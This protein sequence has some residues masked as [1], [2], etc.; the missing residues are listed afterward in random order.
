MYLAHGPISYIL[1]ETIQ[2]KEISKLTKQEQILVMIL[3][4]L[5]GILPDIDLAILSMTNIPPFQHHLIF[6]HSILFFIFLWVLLNIFFW[7][8]K[9]ILNKES[10]IVLK[11]SLLNV[12]QWSFLIGTLSHLFADLLFSYSVSLFPLQQQITILG[13]VFKTNYFANYIFTPSSATEILFISI[14]LM[15]IARRYFK[16]IKVVELISYS[17]IA[18]SSIYL[19][20]AVYMNLNTYNKAYQFE[21][22]IRI[23]DID[24][25]GIKDRIDS[26]TNSNRINNILEVNEEEMVSFVKSISTDRYFVTNSTDIVGKIKYGFGA[27]GSYRLISQAFFDQNLPIE[28]VLVEYAK[29]KYKIQGYNIDIPYPT[30]FYEYLTEKGSLYYLNPYLDTGK[31]FFVIE[32]DKVLNMGI[33]LDKDLFGIVLLNDKKLITHTQED[34]LNDYENAD[35]KVVSISQLE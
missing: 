15:L 23:G 24:Y 27:F 18:L 11:D 1:N 26:D 13:G 21:N 4:I 2:K 7:I 3:S 12:I 28:P 14:F 30:L 29:A 19:L 6:T 16:K 10:R 32:N 33:V 8:L 17:L 9:K 22:N 25:D 5:F 20:F 35:I 34:I 31:I